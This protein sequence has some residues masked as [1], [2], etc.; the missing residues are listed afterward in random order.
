MADSEAWRRQR[1][2]E[3]GLVDGGPRAARRASAVPDAVDVRPMRRP[4]AGPDAAA[5]PRAAPSPVPAATPFPIKRP[6]QRSDTIGSGYN[7]LDVSRDGHAFRLLARGLAL[8]AA[9]AFGWIVHGALDRPPVPATAPV[10]ARAQPSPPPRAAAVAV[11]DVDSAGGRVETRPTAPLP[12]PLPQTRHRP[13]PVAAVTPSPS[14]HPRRLALAAGSAPTA[15]V[16]SPAFETSASAA[17]HPHPAAS[18]PSRSEGA[19]GRSQR[20][21]AL[22]R[23]G[24]GT[25]PRPSFNCRRARATVNRMICGDPRLSALDRRLAAGYR[26]AVRGVDLDT[27]IALDR[28]EAAFLNARGRCTTPACVAQVYED[29]IDELSDLSRP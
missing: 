10:A 2:E 7:R 29:R 23:P 19:A 25:G 13:K 4:A 1:A 24:P 14:A 17:S 20:T 21:L 9:A 3:L 8:S 12:P 27:E 11:Q 16:A 6:P 26:A 15:G 18:A 5:A 22:V 28:D